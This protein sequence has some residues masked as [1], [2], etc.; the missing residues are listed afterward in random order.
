MKD[1]IKYSD[2]FK[3]YKNLFTKK[4]QRYLDLY[5]NQDYSY[6]EIAKSC[7]VSSMTVCDAILRA[8]KQLNFYENSL[9]LVETSKQ[10][11]QLI[12][13]IPD[14]NLKKQLLDLE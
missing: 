5:F 9:K 13:K 6:G 8:K 7:K 12:N 14:E 1:L 4:Q 11:S 2:L 10:R 3:Y